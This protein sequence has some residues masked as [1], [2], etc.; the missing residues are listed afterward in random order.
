MQYDV[1]AVFETSP[2][3]LAQGIVRFVVLLS[4]QELTIACSRA[5]AKQRKSKEYELKRFQ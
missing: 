1:S 2:R 3:I 4:K 5:M